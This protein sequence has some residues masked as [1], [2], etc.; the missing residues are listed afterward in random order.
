MD[1]NILV[2]HE[3]R[4]LLHDAAASGVMMCCKTFLAMGADPNIPDNSGRF[5]LHWVATKA[6][7][8]DCVG[9]FVGQPGVK[10]DEQDNNG[11]TPLHLACIHGLNAIAGHLLNARAMPN[12]YDNKGKSPG[13]YAVEANSV[14]CLQLL[15]SN[16]A[17]V[18]AFD[19]SGHTML[20]TAL[21][22]QR[23]EC[24]DVLLK[25]SPN[26]FEEYGKSKDTP[27]H[28]STEIGYVYGVRQLLSTVD[29]SEVQMLTESANAKGHTALATAVHNAQPAVFQ[30]LVD[31][32][33]AKTPQTADG[34]TLLHVAAKAELASSALVASIVDDCM[35]DVNKTNKAGLS[36]LHIASGHDSF[37][38]AV[39]VR[40]LVLHKASINQP[41]SEGKTALH[42]A[43]LGG[44]IGAL[45]AL[46]ELG[47]DEKATFKDRT[48]QIMTPLQAAGK[49]SV[50]A[51]I[52]FF[53]K[54]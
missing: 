7:G 20:W 44:V 24:L 42:H 25:N 17:N 19:K 52:D 32:G 50:Q 47:A 26:L 37:D 30:L 13:F 22:Q 33:A 45:E 27:M 6:D 11:Q 34:D 36:A 8:T 28:V 40:L 1:I 16:R 31:S 2:D 3:G 5:P 48:G 9:L 54:R 29:A 49:Y 51:T 35:V 39:R 43:A 46:L 12:V 23:N 41:D 4:S 14:S 18:Q 15:L 53:A 21:S 38:T 10:V